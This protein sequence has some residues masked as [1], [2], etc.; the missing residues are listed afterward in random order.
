MVIVKLVRLLVVLA[1]LTVGMWDAGKA[2]A[3]ATGL[4]IAGGQLVEANGAPFIMRGTNYYYSWARTSFADSLTAIKALGANA[5]RIA[6]GGERPER[7]GPTNVADVADI[8]GQCKANRV[9]C[10]LTNIDTNNLPTPQNGWTLGRSADYWLSVKDALLDQEKYVLV[11]I[12]NEPP[13]INDDGTDWTAATVGAI[14]KIRA[15]G[16]NNTIVVDAP[17][18]QDRTFTMRDNA[19]QIL[20]SDHDRNVLFSIHMYG[21]FDTAEK[22]TSYLDSFQSRGLPLV[23]GEFGIDS[24]DGHPDA[25]TIMAQSVVRRMG[26]LGWSWNGN[27]GGQAPYLDQV[28]NLDPSQMTPWGTRLFFGPDGIKS[29]SVPATIFSG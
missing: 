22:I 2:R 15:G 16:I 1:V 17:Y 24:N 10:M 9:I 7:G 12:G 13:P 29:N 21:A 14:A 3:E 26:Y 5:V 23:I 11:N 19:Q 25:A 8:V 6:L 27:S 20:D 18:G 28:T 4:H